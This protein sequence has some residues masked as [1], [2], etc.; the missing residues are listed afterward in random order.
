[1]TRTG[2]LTLACALAANLA[3]ASMAFAQ[4]AQPP[5]AG[6]PPQ[7]MPQAGGPPPGGPGGPGGPPAGSSTSDGRPYPVLFVTSVEVLRSERNGGMDIVRARAIV[8]S[9]L[10]GDPLLLPISH[11]KPSDGILDLIF[12]A[13]GPDGV[14]PAAPFMVVETLLPIAEG[15]P[16]KGVRVRGGANVVTLKTMPGYAESAAPKED[17]S[18]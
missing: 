2:L 5:A 1:M 12:Q 8:P 18:K 13:R 3:F 17:C 15:H 16:F 14:S 11:G 9:N 7:P 10:W 4:Q 6:A